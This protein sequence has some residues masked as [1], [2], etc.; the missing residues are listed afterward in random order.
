MRVEASLD[1]GRSWRDA[2]L[3]EPR[4][5]RAFARSRFPGRWDGSEHVLQSRAFDD[6]GFQEPTVRDLI[7]ASGRNSA[8]HKNGIKS[9]RVSSDGWVVQA[10]G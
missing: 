1:A 9:W 5:P 8:C 7:A 10:S 2:E 4:L 3:Q 6:Q